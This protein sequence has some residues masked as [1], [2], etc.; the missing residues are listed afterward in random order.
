MAPDVYVVPASGDPH[1]PKAIEALSTP[2]FIIK[3]GDTYWVTLA[4]VGYRA[5]DAQT[6]V[7][8]EGCAHIAGQFSAVAGG[9]LEA[10]ARPQA[11]ALAFLSD[12]STDQS[13]APRRPA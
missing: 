12:Q 1:P 10:V 5:A 2:S 11:D 3:D 9:S 13:T 6:T 8:T 7:E 4:V